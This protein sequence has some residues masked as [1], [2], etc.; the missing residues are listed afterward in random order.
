[1]RRHRR[2]LEEAGA[3]EATHISGSLQEPVSST[4]GVGDRL[5]C[6][7]GLACD[8]EEG[9]LGGAFEEDL[10]EVSA[11]DVGAEVTLEVS[12]AVMLEGFGDHN[13]SKV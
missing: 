7:E 10:S 1:M 11:I 9:G 3:A 12:L 4:L 2:E 6:G 8:E 13:G 5:L